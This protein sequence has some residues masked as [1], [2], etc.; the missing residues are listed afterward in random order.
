M[1]HITV[2]WYAGGSILSRL[3]QG[4]TRSPYSH[5]AIGVGDRLYEA[6]A[7]GIVVR[8]GRDKTR[9]VNDAVA[10]TVLP[11]AETD[12]RQVEAFLDQQTGHG[13]SI[14]GFIAAGLMSL[15]GFSLVVAVPGEYIC[16]G[17]VARAI[18]L[19]GYLPGDEARLESPASLADKLEP[20]AT[21]Q[22]VQ[23]GS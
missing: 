16:S 19:A 8:E 21:L 18:Q 23:R 3:I 9:R 13:Y 11:V 17:L 12:Y 5:A 22:E 7:R 6:L 20:T 1:K 10:M 14:L 15:T 4:V 2:H